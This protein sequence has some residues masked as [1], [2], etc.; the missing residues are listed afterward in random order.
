MTMTA[1]TIVDTVLRNL[2]NLDIAVFGQH[3]TDM[4]N[5]AYLER[6][7][8]RS[9]RD[10]RE[11]QATQTASILTTTGTIEEGTQTVPFTLWADDIWIPI[12]WR[13]MDNNERLWPTSIQNLD[14]IE[15]LSS[16]ASTDQYALWGNSLVISPAVFAT[17]SVRVRYI[18]TAAM[19]VFVSD[20]NTTTGTSALPDNE[21]WGVIFRASERFAAI[22]NP[23][24][25]PI[26]A[27]QFAGWERK[28]IS[29]VDQQLLEEGELTAYVDPGPGCNGDL[30]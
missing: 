19:F 9:Y 14:D 2:G 11:L 15:D 21:D 17:R 5:A 18:S 1:Q 22:V 3:A 12:S 26:W 27:S 20:T 24:L 7:Q 28:R 6:A 13:D 8:G 16:A 29:P 23:A 30:F 25:V 4:V 10:F